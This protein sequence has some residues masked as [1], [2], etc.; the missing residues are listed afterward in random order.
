MTTLKQ[1]L[2]SKEDLI[3]TYPQK[4]NAWVNGIYPALSLLDL[5][6]DTTSLDLDAEVVRFNNAIYILDNCGDYPE[7]IY[8][9]ISAANDRIMLGA[10]YIQKAK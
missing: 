4:D 2:S 3:L 6:A 7:Y 5:I 10:P 9:G 8:T 1:Y